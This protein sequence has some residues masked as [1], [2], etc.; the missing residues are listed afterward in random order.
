MLLNAAV[1]VTTLIILPLTVTANVATSADSFSLQSSWRISPKFT[2]SGW[3]G[4][5]FSQSFVNNNDAD[6]LNYAVTLAFRD[7]GG[8][9]NLAGV[10]IS[11]PPKVTESNL[12]ADRDTS[13]H[14]EGF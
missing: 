11:M 12:V 14:I 2:F 6:N 10:V 5:S 7:L 9:G 1:I 3:L 8:K 4:Y 13:L